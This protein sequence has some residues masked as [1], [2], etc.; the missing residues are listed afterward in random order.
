MPAAT[1]RVLV[2]SEVSGGELVAYFLG[3]LDLMVTD[4]QKWPW[5]TCDADTAQQQALTQ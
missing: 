3:D 1:Q 2:T 4:F 5:G